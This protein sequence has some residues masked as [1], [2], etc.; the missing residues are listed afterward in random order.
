MGEG[1]AR[2]GKREGVLWGWHV[3]PRLAFYFHFR[4]TWGK[5]TPSPLFLS[6][7]LLRRYPPTKLV[8][9]RLA[10]APPSLYSLQHGRTN[11]V[12]RHASSPIFAIYFRGVMQIKKLKVRPQKS[13]RSLLLF[14]SLSFFSRFLF[15]FVFFAHLRGTNPHHLFHAI[16]PPVVLCGPQLASMLGCW[17]ATKDVK[18]IGACREHAQTLFECMRTAVRSLSSFCFVSLQGTDDFFYCAR[19]PMKRKQHRPSINYHLARLG[20]TLKD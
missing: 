8:H 15:R 20:K 17:A 14:P 12:K 5:A 10:P 2:R 11:C 7:P 3:S 9:Q 13:T 6:S 19:Q 1:W 16:D 4:H 18:S